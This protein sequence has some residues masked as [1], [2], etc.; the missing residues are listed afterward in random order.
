MKIGREVPGV[1]AEQQ[2]TLGSRIREL[3]QEREVSLRGLAEAIGLS[4]GYLSQIERGEAENPSTQVL[5]KF[6]DGLG[7]P[8]STLLG[9]KSGAAPQAGRM[10]ASL[11]EFL[12]E[13]RR[14]GTPVPEGDAQ[15]LLG[16]R[17]RGRH[18][19]SA[20]DWEL[21]YSVISRIV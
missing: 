19:R 8:I 14:R 17:Y 1:T 7:V 6:A 5:Q 9:E 20:R 13:A 10:P 11:V 16:I 3:R 15:M 12:E 4:P 2:K 18:P 21:L